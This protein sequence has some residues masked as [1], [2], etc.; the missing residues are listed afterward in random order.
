MTWNRCCQSIVSVFRLDEVLNS[1]MLFS[2]FRSFSA[3]I[4]ESMSNGQIFLLV[5]F[6]LFVFNRA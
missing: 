2:H 3:E 5:F 4:Q 6:L 1:E